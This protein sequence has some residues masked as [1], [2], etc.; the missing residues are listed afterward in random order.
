MQNQDY[1]NDWEKRLESFLGI[2]RDRYLDCREVSEKTGYSLQYIRQIKKGTS[3]PSDVFMR[4]FSE[5]YGV[6]DD[7]MKRGEYKMVNKDSYTKISRDIAVIVYRK[8]HEKKMSLK[9]VA[10]RVFGDEKMYHALWVLENAYQVTIHKDVFV[11][12]AR[13]YGL[14]ERILY[15]DD[16]R[17]KA[18]KADIAA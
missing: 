13:F 5:A 6:D 7:M 16:L 4:K 17:A 2:M 1:V 14:D 10:V 15:D 11:P 3:Y 18:M 12:L 8:R 9:D